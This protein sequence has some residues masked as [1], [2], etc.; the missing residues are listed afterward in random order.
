MHPHPEISWLQCSVGKRE[1]QEENG[2]TGKNW[3]VHAP[4]SNIHRERE[5]KKKNE[6]KGTSC[7]GLGETWCLKY[8]VGMLSVL[9][10]T[11]ILLALLIF[12]W[13][14]HCI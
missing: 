2:T 13:V 1:R 7:G 10:V 9:N 3:N 14:T 11:P 8:T 4:P 6:H 5:R 12:F